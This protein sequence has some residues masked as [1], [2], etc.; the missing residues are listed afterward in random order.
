MSS[1]KKYLKSCNRLH[2]YENSFKNVQ[3]AAS[4]YQQTSDLT[5]NVT[6]KYDV[7]CFNTD[8]CLEGDIPTFLYPLPYYFFFH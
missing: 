7:K 1:I 8:P 4:F 5:R 2:S 6:A 3:N